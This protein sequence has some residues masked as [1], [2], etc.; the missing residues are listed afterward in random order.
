[1]SIKTALQLEPEP[2]PNKDN[3]LESESEKHYLPEPESISKILAGDRT[4]FEF[5]P[6]LEPDRSGFG[7]DARSEFL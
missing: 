4:K 7:F 1:M 2:K 5:A 6:D 3:L